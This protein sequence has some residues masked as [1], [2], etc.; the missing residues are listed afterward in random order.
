MGQAAAPLLTKTT[1]NHSGDAST[2]EE[3][4]YERAATSRYGLPTRINVYGAGAL[5]NFRKLQYY[6]ESVSSFVNKYMLTYL[7]S[8]Q[9]YDQS[10][11][12]LKETIFT[13]Y[14]NGAVDSIKKLKSGNTYLTWNYGYAS[15]NPN[16]IT[17]TIDLP[18]TGGTETMVYR[19]GVLTNF[20]SS[21]IYR[22]HS[23]YIRP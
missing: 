18:G 19:Y 8:E 1:R 12:K 5:K 4:L 11:A 23:H 16:L 6:F 15:S 3:Y 2:S 9:Q 13:Y 21:R 14:A 17:I 22:I 7:Q 20:N 10:S